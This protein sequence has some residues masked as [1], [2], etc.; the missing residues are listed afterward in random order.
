MFFKPWKSALAAKNIISSSCYLLIV[1]GVLFCYCGIGEKIPCKAEELEPFSIFRAPLPSAS[2]LLPSGSLTRQSSPVESFIFENSVEKA[3]AFFK[4]EDDQ[5]AAWEVY[6]KLLLHETEEEKKRKLSS[7][8]EGNRAGGGGKLHSPPSIAKLATQTKFPF[9]GEFTDRQVA[10]RNTNLLM[11]TGVNITL[12]NIEEILSVFTKTVKMVLDL[13]HPERLAI[14]EDSPILQDQHALESRYDWL[15]HHAFSNVVNEISPGKHTEDSNETVISTSSFPLSLLHSLRAASSLFLPSVKKLPSVMLMDEEII[16]AVEKELRTIRYYYHV[17]TV[18]PNVDKAERDAILLKVKE[19]EAIVASLLHPVDEL[20]ERSRYALR[21]VEKLSSPYIEKLGPLLI[22]AIDRIEKELIH[23]D[24]ATEEKRKRMKELLKEKTSLIHLQSRILRISGDITKSHY[25]K[26]D[27]SAQS[28]IVG[29]AIIAKYRLN[30]SSG[31]EDLDIFPSLSLEGHLP[32]LGMLWDEF[33]P[34]VGVPLVFATVAI[35]V[36]DVILNEIRRSWLKRAIR[37]SPL[38]NIH[39]RNR[40]KKKTRKFIFVIGFFKIFFFITI[41]CVLVYLKS[42]G[43]TLSLSEILAFST[44]RVRMSFAALF[45][46]FYL[47]LFFFQF[48][49]GVLHNSVRPFPQVI[50]NSNKLKKN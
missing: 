26:K 21:V 46:S 40:I 29:L 1:I 24:E 2:E 30:V 3:R 11:A 32:A 15:A 23:N 42:V 45:A 33:V 50:S 47:L 9:K 28:F 48:V 14:H 38:L 34:L 13:I 49:I 44:P 17:L 43:N 12:D 18:L 35:L 8:G 16:E 5:Y 4:R 41:P 6:K 39:E 19:E 27:I 22:R 37:S 25:R 36:L 10:R 31:F 20:I 7:E